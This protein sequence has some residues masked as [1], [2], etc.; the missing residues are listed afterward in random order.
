MISKRELAGVVVM[1]AAALLLAYGYRAYRLAHRP[2]SIPHSPGESASTRKTI[3][4]ANKARH[5]RDDI[6]KHSINETAD[7]MKVRAAA[8]AKAR[9]H[10]PVDDL[11]GAYVVVPVYSAGSCDYGSRT[12]DIVRVPGDVATRFDWMAIRASLNIPFCQVIAIKGVS[13]RRFINRGGMDT[14]ARRYQELKEHGAF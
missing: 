14:L 10:D 11:F 3:S 9:I 4:A 13:G 5:A 7:E 6:V 2:P 12:K 1:T 8:N